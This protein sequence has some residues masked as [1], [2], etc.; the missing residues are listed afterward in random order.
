MNLEKW[1][2]LCRKAWEN[3]YENLQLERFATI[4][5]GR[6]YLRNYNK[7]SFIECTLETEPF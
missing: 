6:Y 4:G 2:I 1:K 5:E 3:G 7:I